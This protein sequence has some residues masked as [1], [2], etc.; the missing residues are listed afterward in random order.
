MEHIMEF[1][2]VLQNL[3]FL[4]TSATIFS[5]IPLFWQPPSLRHPA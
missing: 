1:C 4:I 5:A 2:P 3:P